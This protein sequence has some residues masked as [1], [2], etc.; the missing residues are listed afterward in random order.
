M[1][2][3]GTWTQT[4][5]V[6]ANADRDQ[7]GSDELKDY[8]LAA[9]L[10]GR[11][12]EGFQIL[13]KAHHS[14]L[15][16]LKVK[17]AARCA[18]WLGFMLMNAGERARG[19]G[20]IARGQRLLADHGI[21]HCAEA[22]LLLIPSALG[23]LS[24][25]ET[26]QAR[27]IFGRIA[28]IG[29]E[30]SDPDVIALGRLGLGQAMIQD[31]RVE[32]GKKLL[33]ET[34]VT[35]QTENVFPL[36][37]GIAYCAVIESCRKV[38]DLRRAQEWTSVLSHWCETQPDLV[39]FRG[40]CLIR[41]AEIIQLHGEWPQALRETMGAC[42]LLN[43]KMD[44]PVAGEAFYRKAELLRLTGDFDQAEDTYREAAKRGR[45]PQPGLAL[46][47][48][49]QEQD[50]AAET[51]IR[52]TL[53]DT[54][55]SIRRIELLPKFILIMLAVEQIEEARMAVD[56]LHDAVQS[57]DA[58][59]LLATSAHCQGAVL[60][61]EREPT[62]ALKHLQLA[63]KFWTAL[64]LPY[65][66]A[67]T[68]ELKAAA[69]LAMNDQD[70]ARV[71]LAS[72]KWIYEQLHAIP[73]LHRLGRM[74]Q[75]SESPPHSLTLRELQVLQLVASGKTNKQA[76]RELFIS[77][78]TVDRHVS[79]ILNK[80]AVSSRAEATAYALRHKMLD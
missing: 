70:N 79:N 46:L 62:S 52:N 34:M 68:R 55:D 1:H 43:R 24:S 17:A 57:F 31:G 5:K 25:R 29:D 21:V 15:D 37:I 3:K 47:R 64:Q 72:A 67:G 35:V 73:D 58:P 30:F 40:Q 33:D 27:S 11:D 80:L 60:L 28:T 38:W 8:A 12:V 14:Y 56:E 18:F 75:K 69:Y 71:E 13:E 6:M 45:N 44:E 19:G 51:S 23:A 66:M 4:Y 41:R 54:H 36:V 77:E 10:T 32:D 76:A 61:A 59:Y 63:L 74:E 9:Y 42:E 50:D 65:E 49:A 22:G 39:P 48:L 7:L 26:D 53:K 2:K 16:Q 20:W 78:R